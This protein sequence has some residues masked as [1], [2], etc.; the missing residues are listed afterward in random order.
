MLDVFVMSSLLTL[1]TPGQGMLTLDGEAFG[2]EVTV[3]DLEHGFAGGRGEMGDG[4]TV[5]FMVQKF[6]GLDALTVT[7][8]N[9]QWTARG[10]EGGDDP[11]IA[12]LETGRV[13]AMG[14]V[15]VFPPVR[16][17][18]VTASVDGAC[19]ALSGSF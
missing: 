8:G 2:I 13:E 19:P 9:E 3:C 17:E 14:T 5:T 15:S 10:P 7:F 16:E 1:S 12:P 6:P 11:A 18:S 4:G